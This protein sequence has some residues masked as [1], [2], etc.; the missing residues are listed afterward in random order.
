MKK[1]F[2]VRIVF[3]DWKYKASLIYLDS[4]YEWN[5][6]SNSYLL[7]FKIEREHVTVLHVLKSAR[8]TFAIT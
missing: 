2:D 4:N 1:W 5:L 7:I 6:M 3:L 8:D